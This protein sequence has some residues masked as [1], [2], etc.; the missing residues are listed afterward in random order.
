M[1][2]KMKKAVLIIFVLA[3]I[4]SGCM[5]WPFGKKA[6]LPPQ[7][8][9]W[10][11]AGYT[12]LMKRLYSEDPEIRALAA[13]RLV[14]RGD[15]R[16]VRGISTV[17]REAQ[18]PIV[19]SVLKVL[20]L[21]PDDRYIPALI[22]ILEN[23][24]PSLHSLIFEVFKYYEKERL[25]DD[26]LYRITQRD[27]SLQ[28]KQNVIIAIGKVRSKKAVEPL[29]RLFGT[30]N[31]ALDNSV[32]EALAKITLQRFSTKEEWL[33]WWSVYKD[34]PREVWL[35]EALNGYQ[36]LIADKNA[37][38]DDLTNTIASL[39]IELLNIKLDQARKTQSSESV[40]SL[41]LTAI[42]DSNW[43]IKK[44]ALEQ[45][46]GLSKD[47]I[48]EFQPKLIELLNSPEE[49][50]K[51]AVVI[52]LAEIPEEPIIDILIGI[53]TNTKETV[54]VR[55]SSANALGKIGS[56]RAT[57]SLVGVLSDASCPLVVAVIEALGKIKDK[58]SIQPLIKLLD[59]K[60]KPAE[61][62][63]A[64]IDILGEIKDPSCV[65]AIIKFA[66]DA[67]DRFR[68]SAA[69]SLGKLGYE[70]IINPL[71]KLLKDDFADIRQIS[72]E[73]LGNIGS[74]TA[75]QPLVSALV[76]DK[77]NRV[78]ELSA[79]A[80]GKIKSKSALPELIN[81]LSDQNERVVNAIWTSILAII[82][83]DIALMQETAKKLGELKQHPR[84]EEIYKKIIEISDKPEYI[85]TLIKSYK[86][87]G[88]TDEAINLY[89]KLL[90]KE[91][92]NTPAWWEIKSEI[93][94]LMHEK[95]DY[96]KCLDEIKG[97]LNN[98]SIPSVTKE[99]LEK[100][101]S[102]CEKALGQK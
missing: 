59:D 34:K 96:A 49:G 54:A 82:S 26:L 21:R 19:I 27:K 24:S 93:L 46:P 28:A 51:N 97:L 56:N 57:D 67:R 22:D 43:Q 14:A 100:L 94:G 38:I 73:A 30:E 91:Q 50:V 99:T 83:D 63:R 65:E 9:D 77:D 80:L 37:K 62:H 45:V 76:N 48:K 58:T 25:T 85:K 23:R 86:E 70:S 78:R 79:I 36:K 53:V 31:A 29:I 95:K 10:E 5:L 13:D 92:A 35:D 71:V 15:K 66:D 2:K 90:S 74:E 3:F 61:I 42:S 41:L 32:N 98:T 8:L 33:E 6:E 11:G 69:N 47:K 4:S 75:V 87:S 52:T 55:K 101:K 39:K 84:A 16:A 20:A 102:E 68:W 18:D 72:A 44:Y 64:I 88:K 17:L 1:G 60:T 40:S 7:P 89:N 81:S 12:E